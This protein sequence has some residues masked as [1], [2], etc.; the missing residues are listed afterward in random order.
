MKYYT[1]GVTRNFSRGRS[2][3]KQS[4][5]S[6]ENYF[7][8]PPSVSYLTYLIIPPYRGKIKKKWRE[9]R[10][11]FGSCHPFRPPEIF[12][13]LFGQSKIKPLVYYFTSAYSQI[14]HHWSSPLVKSSK[15][16]SAKRRNMLPHSL[17]SPLVLTL[18]IFYQTMRTCFLQVP[19]FVIGWAKTI[20]KMKVFIQAVCSSPTVSK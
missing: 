17:V 5:S 7:I 19:D 13:F 18:S 10:F 1:K 3:K 12:F 8:P 14:T 16:C 4:S 6:A 11:I 20:S 2:T 9:I 15:T